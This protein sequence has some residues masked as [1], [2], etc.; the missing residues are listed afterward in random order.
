MTSSTSLLF[1]DE[2]VRQF[3]SAFDSDSHSNATVIDNTNGFDL[4]VFENYGISDDHVS[5]DTAVL[6]IT[7]FLKE[8]RFEISASAGK[9]LVVGLR[10]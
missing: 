9:I 5:T 6:P 10:L 2:T 7:D 8:T 4:S 1:S 3:G